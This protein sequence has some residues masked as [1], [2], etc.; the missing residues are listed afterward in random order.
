MFIEPCVSMQYIIISLQIFNMQISVKPKMQIFFSSIAINSYIIKIKTQSNS[1][2]KKNVLI[3]KNRLAACFFALQY[4]KH[5]CDILQLC[6]FCHFL[7]RNTW[8][9]RGKWICQYDSN[10]PNVSSRNVPFETQLCG[11]RCNK[12]ITLR[13]RI[14]RQSLNLDLYP[15]KLWFCKKKTKIQ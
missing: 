15:T 2:S 13:L 7:F 1:D 4:N 9:Q 10:S 14:V 8:H 11:F 6:D 12:R 3:R 5:F